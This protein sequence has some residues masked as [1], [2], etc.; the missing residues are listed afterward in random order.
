MRP[1][2]S[3]SPVERDDGRCLSSATAL[4]LVSSMGRWHGMHFSSGYNASKA[5]LS[6][7]GESLEMELRRHESRRF[8]VTIVEPGLFAS[9]MTRPTPLTR[10]LFA[11]RRQVASRIVSGALAGRKAIRPPF[12]FALL[13]WA[14]CLMGRNFR[15]RLFARAKPRANQ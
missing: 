6:I 15:Y 13:T 9:G 14:A 5:A 11:S 12:A 10:L 3:P 4:V 8:T 2:P 1:E 7:W